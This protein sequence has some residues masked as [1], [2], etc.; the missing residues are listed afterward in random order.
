M[1]QR[2]PS[3]R[4]QHRLGRGVWELPYF[5]PSG[6]IILVAVTQTNHLLTWRRVRDEA[7]YA[8]VRSELERELD[9]DDPVRLRLE[10]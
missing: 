7:E 9:A 2:M 4:L 6:A 8:A 1:C 10:G 3:L 5:D